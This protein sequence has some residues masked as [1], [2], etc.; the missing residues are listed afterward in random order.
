VRAKDGTWNYEGLGGE[1]PPDRAPPQ[2]T[3]GPAPAGGGAGARLVVEEARIEDG[4]LSFVDAATGEAGAIALSKIDLAAEG[5]PGEASVARLSAALAA[6]AKNVEL[7]VRSPRLPT[8]PGAL[9]EVEG[10][11]A[12]RGI[13]LDRLRGLL[14]ADV[15]AMVRG[16]RADVEAKVASEPG[17]KAYTLDGSGRL[18]DVRLQGEPA[19]GSFR[20]RG[21]ADPRSG[22]ARLEVRDLAVKGPGV[23][24]GGTA[25]LETSPLRARFALKGALLDVGTV[26]GLVPEGPAPTRPASAAPAGGA[27]GGAL[28]PP[29]MAKQ[30]R[31]VTVD[32]TIELDEVVNGKLTASNVRA[33]AA[34]RGGVLAIEQASAELYGGRADLG[35]TQVHLADANPKWNLKAK[36]DSVD[37]GAALTAVTGAAPLTGRATGTLDLSGV[38]S[39]WDRLKQVLT[40][41]GGIRIADGALTTTAIG[42]QALSAI[43]QGLERAG[44]G[45]AGRKVA[46]V[47]GGRTT[48]R[49]LAATFTVQDGWM[50]LAKPV[51]F[52]TAV[53]EARLGGRVGLSQE[54]AL[55]GA[56]A[57]TREALARAGLPPLGGGPLELPMKLGGSLGGP[58]VSFDAAGVLEGAARGLVEGKREEVQGEVKR[59]ARRRAED[60]L[61]RFG[62]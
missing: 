43:A 55:D 3:A 41:S 46:S 33:K 29:A 52:A 28:L 34:L 22:A 18:A 11:V 39:N 58:S 62:R 14:P 16:G 59:Q 19:A 45:A 50:A 49:D 31:D 21:R 57:V 38:G 2:E 15:A 12:L 47:E 53:G 10:T 17:A 37:L 35:G 6:D 40:G 13:A 1:A 54:L 48:L 36:L 23:D 61:R 56:L 30:V 51:A 7:E 24:V 9:P 27:Q 5:G 44:R 42:D 26:L 32:G 60:A 20:L 25:T 4:T 8:E